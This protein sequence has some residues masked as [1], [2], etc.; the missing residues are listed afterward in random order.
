MGVNT[1]LSKV[2]M[3]SST[4]SSTIFVSGFFDYQRILHLQ[5]QEHPRLIVSSSL[6]ISTVIDDYSMATTISACAVPSTFI[7]SEGSLVEGNC[8]IQKL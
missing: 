6:L 7:H 2:E 3:Y 1:N 4:L 8:W 5:K